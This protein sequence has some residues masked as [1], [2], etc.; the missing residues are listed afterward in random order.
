MYNCVGK[1]PMGGLSGSVSNGNGLLYPDSMGNSSTDSGSGRVSRV[2]P[3]QGLSRTAP[4]RLQIFDDDS[5]DEAASHL[6]KVCTT[7]VLCALA[8]SGF[9]R[10]WVP[11]ILL[12]Y[13]ISKYLK[14]S[15]LN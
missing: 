13:Q 10:V 15:F 1:G 4:G 9:S 3:G 5:G 8:Y 11:S 14:F 12:N 7:P 2:E 6:V